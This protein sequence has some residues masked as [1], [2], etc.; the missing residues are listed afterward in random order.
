MSKGKGV[1]GV[2]DIRLSRGNC[3]YKSWT[4]GEHGTPRNGKGLE[5]QRGNTE[6]ELDTFSSG[7]EEDPNHF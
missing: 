4:R 5:G 6:P 2:G 3:V 7:Q 1:A